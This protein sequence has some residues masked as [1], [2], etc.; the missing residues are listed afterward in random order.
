[1]INFFVVEYFILWV[2]HFGYLSTMLDHA[3]Q[4][5]DLLQDSIVL[6]EDGSL[7]LVHLF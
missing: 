4:F 1:M 5:G 6:G 2:G 7:E 3:G